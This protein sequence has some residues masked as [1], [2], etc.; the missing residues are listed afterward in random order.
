VAPQ[1]RLLCQTRHRPLL[2]PRTVSPSAP[3]SRQLPAHIL[4]RARRSGALRRA[5]AGAG[6]RPGCGDPGAPA[7]PLSHSCLPLPYARRCGAHHLRSAE[8]WRR[9]GG[10]AC[11]RCRPQNPILNEE[12]MR[13]R[14]SPTQQVRTS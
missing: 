5:G 12:K 11:R 2:Q 6:G 1:L 3:R 7:C 4:R 13:M 9:P 10:H 14:A 8:R